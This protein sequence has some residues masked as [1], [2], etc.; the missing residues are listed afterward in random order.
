MN[1]P[2]EQLQAL[3]KAGDRVTLDQIE[4]CAAQGETM[5]EAVRTLLHDPATWHQDDSDAWWLPLHAAFILGKMDSLA[6][7]L[8]LVELM[9]L[10]DRHNEQDLQDWLADAWPGLFANKPETI[11]TAVSELT[12]DRSVDEFVRQMARR[13][14]LSCA[15]RQGEEALDAVIDAMA[16][17]VADTDESWFMRELAALGMLDHPRERHRSLMLDFADQCASKAKTKPWLGVPFDHRD[18]AECFDGKHT[19]RVYDRQ[20][21]PWLFYH[22]RE[23]E[24]RQQR[25]RKEA[26]EAER[27]ESTAA[28]HQ[29]MPSLQ[30]PNQIPIMKTETQVRG[31]AKPGRNDPCP[32]GSG[33]KYKKCCAITDNQVPPAEL[34]RRRIRRETEGLS[35]KILDFAIDRYGRDVIPEAWETFAPLDSDLDEGMD[36]EHMGV[37]GPWFLYCWYPDGDDTLVENPALHDVR[38]A[39]AY[40]HEKARHLS[41]TVVAYVESLLSR[42]YRFYEVLEVEPERGLILQDLMDGS[43]HEVADRM[44]SQTLRPHDLVYTLLAEVDGVNVFEG[45]SEIVIPALHKLEVL[46]LRDEYLDSEGVLPV[47]PLTLENLDYEARELYFEIFEHLHEPLP[48]RFILPEGDD[49]EFHNLVYDIDAPDEAFLVLSR[50][51]AQH[52][53]ADDLAWAISART[54]EGGVEQAR[55]PL[56]WSGEDGHFKSGSIHAEVQIKGQ[57]LTIQVQSR[58]RAEWIKDWLTTNLG[59]SARFRL[60]EVQSVESLLANRSGK[61]L[62]AP[63]PSPDTAEMLDAKA[64]LLRQHYADWIDTPLPALDHATPRA[65]ATTPA[66]RERVAALI[67]GAA[68]IDLGLPEEVVESIFAPIRTQLGLE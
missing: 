31:S 14:E 2:L 10:L 60:D 33:K 32:C 66:G 45:L 48:Q 27:P 46:R 38:P 54:A 8:L 37:F 35:Q 41:P 13:I 22:P 61:S 53:E 12:M 9:R 24:A 4:A 62:P 18:V 20:I 30:V 43:R 3:G 52:E 42:Q 7:G 59:A 36:P 17:I 51:A 16:G 40:L 34:I 57:R 25:W 56:D 1:T 15:Q 28:L 23:I 49:L 67:D 21:N 44:A 39:Q 5:L 68:N 11:L 6:A 19:V 64:A 47:D 29:A 50:I 65:V 55:F 26:A 63:V 58:E